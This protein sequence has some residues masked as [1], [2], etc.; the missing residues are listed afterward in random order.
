MQKLK[1]LENLKFD[2]LVKMNNRKV[3][4]FSFKSAIIYIQNSLHPAQQKLCEEV[5][6]RHF[7]LYI[8]FYYY[9][10]Y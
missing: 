5:K 8:I 3:L 4:T 6:K 2:I 1:F 10:H 9:K 7:K